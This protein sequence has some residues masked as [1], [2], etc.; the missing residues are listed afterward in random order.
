MTGS[1][2]HPQAWHPDS[3]QKNAGFVAALGV[4]VL[5]L[6]APQAHED[7]LDLGCG[8]G[9]LTE[10]LVRR[11]RSVTGIDASPEQI[12]GA[13]SKGLDAHVMDGQAIQLNGKYDAVFSNAALHW[14]VDAD[15]VIHGV[16][17]VLKPGGRFVGEFGGHGNVHHIRTA[18][19]RALDD[20]GFNGASFN[21]WFFPS[22]EEYE[23]RLKSAGFLVDTIQ[24]IDR[25][26]E[27]PGDVTGWLATFAESYLDAL[28]AGERDD[29]IADVRAM[30]EPVLK[31]PDGQWFADYV[32]LRFA[33]HLPEEV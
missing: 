1:K 31:R 32:R 29:Y 9:V 19:E 12:E 4:P 13:R 3:Y 15:A 6:L 20:R 11:C 14:M 27:L 18:L 7:I 28:P 22:V 2:D 33:A 5:D 30:L 26:T 21:P 10:A 25:P 17:G 24:L 16:R 8:D 23:A